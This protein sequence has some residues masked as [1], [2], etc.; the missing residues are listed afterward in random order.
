MFDVQCS[1]RRWRTSACSPVASWTF[2]FKTI[3]CDPENLTFSTYSFY[4]TSQEGLCTRMPVL[5]FLF[6]TINLVLYYMHRKLCILH[7]KMCILTYRKTKTLII[8]IS[9]ILAC[10]LQYKLSFL[11]LILSMPLLQTR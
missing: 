4:F 10:L 2:I 8:S 1:I 3:L 7:R 9:C 5:K 11:Y 6:E